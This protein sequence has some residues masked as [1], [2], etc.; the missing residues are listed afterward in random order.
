MVDIHSSSRPHIWDTAGQTLVVDKA[1]ALHP[2]PRGFSRVGVQ[3]REARLD[4]RCRRK[5]QANWA[6]K[7]IGHPAGEK[8]SCPF[9]ALSSKDILSQNVSAARM[10][11]PR[12]RTRL[13]LRGSHRH[14]LLART[15]G[16]PVAV[17]VK[18]SESIQVEKQPC[19]HET[20]TKGRT[21]T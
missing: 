13:P 14:L 7:A 10:S 20:N 3:K 5:T 15:D 16:L 2:R 19:L 6:L 17:R 8:D 9:A 12:A 21:A 18:V 1:E 11:T 4:C